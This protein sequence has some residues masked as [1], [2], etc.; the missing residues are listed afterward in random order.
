ML[1]IAQR[2]RGTFLAWGGEADR[3]RTIEAFPPSVRSFLLA[4]AGLEGDE[5]PA[6]AYYRDPSEWSLLTTRRLVWSVAGDRAAL[7]YREIRNVVTSID[8]CWVEGLGV[9][10]VP[11]LD[12]VGGEGRSWRIPQE[13]G[14]ACMAMWNLLIALSGKRGTAAAAQSLLEAIGGDQLP[15]REPLFR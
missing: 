7:A 8:Y 15:E 13:G 3:T 11:V 9:R 4:E 2:I 6:V 14:A 5:R 12:V 10:A 1:T